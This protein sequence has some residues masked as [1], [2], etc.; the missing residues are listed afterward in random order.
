[1]QSTTRRRSSVVAILCAA[2]V[3]SFFAYSQASGPRYALVIGNGNYAELS[4]LKNPANDAEDIAK[5]LKTLGFK[6]VK[7]LVDAD[8]PTMEDAVDRLGAE[9]SQSA[10]SVGFFF[11]AG[12]GVQAGGMNYLIPADAHIPTD[13]YL[14]TKAMPAQVVMETLQGSRNALN[15]VVMDACRDNPFSWGRSASRGLSVVASQPPGSIVAYAT[16]AGSVA[17]DGTGRKRRLHGRATQAD[18]NAGARDQGRVQPHGEGGK[19]GDGG[20]AGAGGIQPVLRLGLPRGH[21]VRRPVRPRERPRRR[22]RLRS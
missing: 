1:M 11:Y 13:A 15:I 17:Q 14:K 7:L 9:L 10:D 18:R 6:D 19:P 21:A 3:Q 22:K 4:K 5:A 16:S 2:M 12:H 8:L 20:Q